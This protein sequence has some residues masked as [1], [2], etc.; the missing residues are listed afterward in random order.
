MAHVLE[1]L[2][3]ITNIVIQ[4]LHACFVGAPVFSAGLSDH[5]VIL[6]WQ[7]RG[8][9]HACRVVPDEERLLRL[10][11]IV[12][13]EEVDNLGRD[14]LVHGLRSLQRQRALILAALVRRRPV[15]GCAREHRTRWRQASRRLGINGRGIL[16]KSWDRRVLARRRE[17]LL[18]RCPVDIRQAY[19]LHGV[20]VIQIPPELLEAVRGRQGFSVIS[21]MVLAELAGVVAEIE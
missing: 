13:V 18:G 3:D 20:E 7:H 5:G 4:L 2:Q 14:L 16:R 6:G 12:A 9:V 17:C 19:S 10:L 11:G 21:E 1:F 8:D 15:G